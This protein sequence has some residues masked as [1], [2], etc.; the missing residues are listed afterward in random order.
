MI[1]QPIVH[2]EEDYLLVLF[3]KYHNTYKYK[4]ILDNMVEGLKFKATNSLKKTLLGISLQEVNR[5]EE[6]T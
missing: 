2:L 6:N 4:Y 5:L 1:T 3:S